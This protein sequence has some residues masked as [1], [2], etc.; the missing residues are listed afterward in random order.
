[1]TTFSSSEPVPRSLPERA[2]VPVVVVLLVVGTLYRLLPVFLGQPALAE[3]FLTED[4]YLMLTVARSIALGEGMTVAAG[5]IPT[6][7]VQPL[8]TY[9]FAVPYMVTGGDKVSSLVGVHLI[10]TGVALL[11]AIAMKRFAAQV[12]APQDDDERWS[13]LAAALWF[14]GPLL[15]LHTMN[16]LETGLYTLVILVT[17]LQFSRVLSQGMASGG[18]AR[19]AL[20]ALCGL[21]FLARNDAAFLV[22]AIFVLWGLH[23]LVA[24]R[25]GL[26]AVLRRIVPPGLLSLLLAL[27]WLVNNQLNFGSI[28][29][30]SGAAQSLTA[31][32]G[33]N[34][35]LLPSKVFEY[36]FPML[37]V[38]GALE[39]VTPAMIAFGVAACLILPWFAF[40]VWQRGGTVRLVVAAY[41][42][43]A[44]AI[45]VYYGLFFGA[46]HFFS[47]YLAPVAPILI[48]AS[49]VVLLDLARWTGRAR[50]TA[51]TAGVGL[52]GLAL[53]VIL[54]GRLLL[55]GVTE[56]GHFHVVRWVEANVP[57]DAWVGAVQTGTLGYW[58]DRTINLDGKVNPDALAARRSKGHVLDYVVDSEIAYIADWNGIAIWAEDQRAGFSD[59]FEL[60]VDRPGDNLAVLKRREI[61]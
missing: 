60:V 43:H 9:L 37:P 25:L 13:W 42:A 40:R 34:A 20:G 51:V 33:Q 55:P 36:L 57:E 22:I 52:A 39:T 46:P 19:L 50:A 11:G 30:I 54:L 44:I 1:M 53:S 15:V 2:L 61:Q 48:L 29:P 49:I 8:A 45:C 56:Q 31:R 58:H 35:D 21:A 5:T 28:V 6:N 16:G 47:R 3:M 38:P 18:G 59:R 4:G 23:D 10:A 41:L 27:P 14:T 26:V 7:G 17:L 12:L 24:L 32:F